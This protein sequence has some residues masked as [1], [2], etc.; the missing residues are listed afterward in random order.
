MFFFL[1]FA[2]AGSSQDSV[3][4]SIPADQWEEKFGNH[5]AIIKVE[6]PSDAVRIDFLW[7]MS[8]LTAGS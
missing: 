2:Q 5:R 8:P 7:M 1:T 4:Y 6:K 3:P